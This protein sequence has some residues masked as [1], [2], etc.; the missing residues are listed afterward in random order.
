[1]RFCEDGLMHN[2]VLGC[3]ETSISGLRKEFPR[4]C[5]CVVVVSEHFIIF[6]VYA[7][8]STIPLDETIEE[9]A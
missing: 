2:K 8:V 3:Q 9:V 4:F 7:C 5:I 6:C 1:M